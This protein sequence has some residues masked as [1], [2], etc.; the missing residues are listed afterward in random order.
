MSDIDV[1][2]VS[3][4]SDE[5]TPKPV[6]LPL[7]RR[8]L[9]DDSISVDPT[10]AEAQR[11]A[12]SPD[13]KYFVVTA[14]PGDVRVLAGYAT[15]GGTVLQG[16]RQSPDEVNGVAYFPSGMQAAGLAG[17][18]VLPD[19]LEHDDTL[20]ADADFG[21]NVP[22]L[23]ERVASVGAP[24]SLQLVV[25]QWK[26][27]DAA[28]VGGTLVRIATAPGTLWSYRNDESVALRRGDLFGFARGFAE[29]VVL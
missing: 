5:L 15:P 7:S 27:V 6:T 24:R 3:D 10:V 19:D 1:S 25:V 21:D 13:R 2:D 8:T 14:T 29:C 26:D 22:G 20:Q 28:A 23:I 16:R 4:V 17:V 18:L 9:L 11:I 12:R